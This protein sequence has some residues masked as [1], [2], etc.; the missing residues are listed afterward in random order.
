MNNAEWG[1]EEENIRCGSPPHSTAEE[2]THTGNGEDVDK[3]RWSPCRYHYY[4]TREIAAG[5]ELLIKYSEFEDKSQV[6]WVEFGVG[7]IVRE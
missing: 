6:G 4:A 7:A 5:E 2:S 3:E 1:A